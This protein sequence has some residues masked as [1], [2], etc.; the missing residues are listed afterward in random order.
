M[1]FIAEKNSELSNTWTITPTSGALAG[2]TIGTV[3]GVVFTDV[4]FSRG[5]VIG[6]IKSVWG[7]ALKMEG[8]FNDP[9]TCRALSI[10]RAFR[11]KADKPA[12]AHGDGFVDEITGRSL[13][14]ARDAILMG[15]AIYW[16]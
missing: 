10:G 13:K 14:R 4:E 6:R 9:E 1:N 2:D 12:C 11:S 15:P 16:R 5:R 8:V 3:D 7:L